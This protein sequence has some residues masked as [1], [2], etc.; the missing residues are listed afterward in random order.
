ML[1]VKSETCADDIALHKVQLGGVWFG[2][3]ICLACLSHACSRPFL[4]NIEVVVALEH[5]YS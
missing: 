1:E 3:T 2:V 4:Q 5:E